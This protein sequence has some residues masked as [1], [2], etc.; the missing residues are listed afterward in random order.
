MYSMT[1]EKLQEYRSDISKKFT[2][3]WG[4]VGNTPLIEILYRHEGSVRTIY[5]KCEQFNLTGSIKDR[6]AL[7]QLQRA[8]AEKKIKPYSRIVEVSSGHSGISMAAIGRALGHRVTILMPDWLG[9]D[10][11]DIIRCLGA[12]LI[13]VSKEDGGYKGCINRAQMMVENDPDLFLSGQFEPGSSADVHTKTTAWEI[14][15]Q[16]EHAGLKPD[17]FVAGVCTGDTLMGMR[18]YLTRKNPAIKIHPLEPLESQQL[19]KRYKRIGHRIT[20]ICDGF[21]HS[22]VDPL[23]VDTT[24]RVADGDAIHMAHK[25]ATDLGLAV[26]ISSAANI[27]GAMFIQQQHSG[28]RVVVTV[29]PDANKKYIGPVRLRDK[30][31]LGGYLSE[32]I[33]LLDYSPLQRAFEA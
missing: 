12:E 28:N 25:L 18:N 10:K 17:A 7:Y 29:L 22:R 14:W 11:K 2:H 31:P 30:K 23:Q 24:L 6:V 32:Q 33:E 15:S 20:G 13:L 9:V 21:T 1:F 19:S 3:L 5:A 16:L 4:V 27:L 8:Y 26:G